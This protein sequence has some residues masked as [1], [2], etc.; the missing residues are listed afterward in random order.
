MFTALLT[1][2]FIGLAALLAVTVVAAMIGLVVSVI[3]GVVGI[4]LFKV[5]PLL[6]IGW[7]IVKL[8]QRSSRRGSLS[9]ADRR[10]LDEG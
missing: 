9:A 7:V 5:L 4:L 3:L 8:V 1:F 6:L 2:F 10:W